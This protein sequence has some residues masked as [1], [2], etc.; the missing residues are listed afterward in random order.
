MSRSKILLFGILIPLLILGC[1]EHKSQISIIPQPVEIYQQEGVFKFTKQSQIVFSDVSLEFIAQLAS[2]QWQPY[3]GRKLKVTQTDNLEDAQRIVLILGDNETSH[4][5][6][7]TLKIEHDNIKVVANTPAGVLYGVQTIYQLI[8]ANKKGTI[9]CATIVDYPRFEHRGMHLDVVRHFMPLEFVYKVLDYMAIHKLNRFHWHLTDDQGWRLEIKKYPKLTEVGAWRVDMSH[10]HWDDRPVVD[11]PENATYGGFYTQEEVRAVVEYAAQRNIEVMPEI[12]VPAHAMA[13]LAGYPHFSCTGEEVGMPTG[14]VWPIT[15]IL[16]AGNDDVYP[17][18]ED[19]LV[20]VMDLFPSEFIHMGGDEADKTQWRACPKCQQRIK[21]LNLKDEEELQGYFMKRVENFLTENGRVMVGWDEILDGGDI[22]N[23]VVM[24]WR[25]HDGGYQAAQQGLRAIMTPT[26]HCYF[27]YYQGFAELEPLAIG[28]YIPLQKVYE[29]E[30]IPEGLTPEQEKLIMGGQ[31]NHWGEFIPT[32]EH[33]EYMAFP[34]M[35]AMAEVLWSTKESRDWPDFTRRMTQQ[36]ERYD[37]LGIN[38][39]L[40]AFQV[41]VEAEVDSI[42]RALILTLSTD[43][44]ADL[45]GVEI[46]YTLDGTEPT[47][48][49][50]VYTEPIS[51]QSS[52]TLKAVTFKDGKPL[53]KSRTNE[54]YVHKAFAS[55]VDFLYPSHIRYNGKTPRTLV[56]GIFGSNSH[57]DGHWK[58]FRGHD[59]VTTIE[60]FEPTDVETISVHTLQNKTSWIFFPSE[61]I[62]EVS[63]NGTDYTQVGY[64]LPP[65]DPLKGG[66]IF[67]TFTNDMPAENVSH[68]R[69]TLKNIKTCPEGHIGAGNPAFVFVSEIVVE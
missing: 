66:K 64:G 46:R 21:D 48:R 31:G 22:S 39:A 57:H 61:A 7:Y 35:A 49:S 1:K 25:S 16:C 37:K 30:P 4:P 33:M 44:Q 2:E 56:D 27:D 58:G 3:L 6:G 43:T 13:I 60:L 26:S 52:S 8:S 9:P 68:I 28:G 19:I 29:F 67:H 36:Y 40:S 54:Y 59:M 41:G 24:S 55:K 17:F 18:I 23:A 38:Y 11:D 69:V 63:S 12:E 45:P 10:R 65:V 34:R 14:G 5:E 62:I 51:I 15:H 32:T 50:P 53:G 47:R 20:E 42:N